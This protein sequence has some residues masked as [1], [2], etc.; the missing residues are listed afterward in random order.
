MSP[1]PGGGLGYIPNQV[2][3][4]GPK[5]VGLINADG[6]QA[7]DDFASQRHQRRVSGQKIAQEI[8]EELEPTSIGFNSRLFIK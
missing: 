4:N 2:R 8:K 5:E 6:L 3:G 7:G 1:A